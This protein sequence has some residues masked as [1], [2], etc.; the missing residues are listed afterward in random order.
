[1]SVLEAGGE[2]EDA[3]RGGTHRLAGSCEPAHDIFRR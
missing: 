3:G 1:M 2:A